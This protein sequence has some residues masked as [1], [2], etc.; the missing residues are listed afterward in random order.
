M[1]TRP[2]TL[3]V[4]MP[5]DARRHADCCCNPYRVRVSL[6]ALPGAPVD[7]TALREFVSQAGTF[8]VQVRESRDLLQFAWCV[9]GMLRELVERG[10]ERRVV[11]TVEDPT[12]DRMARIAIADGTFAEVVGTVAAISAL[13]A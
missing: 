9:G 10:Y 6:S 4:R 13:A 8:F 1:S 5:I 3:V 7:P 11:V 12:A 2:R